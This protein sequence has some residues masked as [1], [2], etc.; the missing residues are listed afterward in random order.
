MTQE[1]GYTNEFRLLFR[2]GKL[3]SFRSEGW[4]GQRLKGRDKWRNAI[5]HQVHQLKGAKIIGPMLALSESA[6]NELNTVS[7]THDWKKRFD[8]TGQKCSLGEMFYTRKLLHRV[9]PN[10]DLMK[11]TGPEFMVKVASGRKITFLEK[12]QFYLDEICKGSEFVNLDERID[13]VEK[14]HSELNQDTK[15][16][17]NLGGQ[18]YWAFERSFAHTVEQDIFDRLR[19]NGVNINSPSEIPAFIEGQIVN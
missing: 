5:E 7:L 19:D 13:D 10:P 2:G 3:W 1:Y 9:N 18:E 11:A 16:T 15:L 14:R 6:Q 12:L 4:K 17:K 8:I